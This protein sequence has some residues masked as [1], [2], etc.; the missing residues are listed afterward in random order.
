MQ[1]EDMLSIL[2]AEDEEDIRSI[3]QIA[4]EDIGGFSV[5][6]CTNGL[7]ALQQA[8]TIIPDLLLLDVMMPD[9]DGPDTLRE[10]RKRPG[11][12]TIPAIFMTAK[13]QADEVEEY[14]AMGAIDVI[15]KP[16]DPMTLAD[17]LKQAWK[18]HHGR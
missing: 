4:L 7:N 17:A 5:T 14:K 10:L 13:I 11:Y 16:F 15:P 3:A 2:Y 18:A 1:N 9:M 8:D 6:Y 12:A